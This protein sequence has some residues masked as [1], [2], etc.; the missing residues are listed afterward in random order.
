MVEKRPIDRMRESGG[1]MEI[2]TPDDRSPVSLAVEVDEKLYVV[3]AKGIYEIKLADQ[4]DPQRTN[5][6]VPNTQQKIHPYGSE[7]EIVSRTLLTA[8]EL[9]KQNFFE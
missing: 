5:P 3:K 7:N 6:N 9:T 8:I 1:S 2:G 4:I